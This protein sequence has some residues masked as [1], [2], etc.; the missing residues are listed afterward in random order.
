M[1]A[2]R[3]LCRANNAEPPLTIQVN[4]LKTS[5]AELSA[6]LR[7]AGIEA[8]PGALPDSFD[9]PPS[10]LISALPGYDEGHFYV[11]DAAARLAVEAAAPEKGMSVLDACSAP[12]GKSFAAAIRMG[13]EGSILACDLKEKRLKRVAE[14]AKRPRPRGTYR[15]PRHG[16]AHARRGTSRPAST[17]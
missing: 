7:A 9:L 17:S 15:N 1:R 14:G 8:A 16:R 3:A 2:R 6:A 5:S 4:T 13:G 10:G 12:G 11:Q